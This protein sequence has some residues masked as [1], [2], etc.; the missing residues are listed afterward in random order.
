MGLAAR[1]E[2]RH[3]HVLLLRFALL[4]AAGFA[5][6]IAVYFQG[7]LDGLFDVNVRLAALIIVAVFIYGLVLCAIKIWQTTQALDDIRGG[8]FGP[9]SRARRY[10]ETADFGDAES[11]TVQINLLRL[12]LTHKIA[13]VRQI[14]NILVFLG[15][16]GTVIGFIVALSGVDAKAAADTTHVARMIGTLISGMSVALYT[17]L[18]GAVLNL[19]LSINYRML[20]TGTVNLLGAIVEL[21]EA[22]VGRDG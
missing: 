22:K 9:E 3:R 5:L 1:G 21:G 10:L 16:I 18:L 7:W 4:N 8:T 14:A 17:T 19:W 15:L 20:A 2:Q 6:C 11:R 12:R 13:S